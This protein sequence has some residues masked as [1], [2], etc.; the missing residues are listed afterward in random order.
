MAKR[1]SRQSDRNTII[2]ENEQLISVMERVY[3]G[4]VLETIQGAPPHA[5]LPEALKTIFI[6]G[7]WLP[8]KKREA[9]E[10]YRVHGLAR[11]IRGESPLPPFEEYIFDICLELGLETADDIELLDGS[12]FLPPTEDLLMQDRIE[13]EF[14]PKFSISDAFYRLEY[15]VSRKRLHMIQ[16]GG[17][18][19]TAPPLSMQPKKKGWTLFW[20][21]KNRTFPL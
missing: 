10:R 8:E 11:A 12:E 9:L 21:Y 4:R 15:D 7:K 17:Q 5:L 14:P 6:E 18:R 1:E 20:V 19:K 2:W 16:T 13:K 3:A